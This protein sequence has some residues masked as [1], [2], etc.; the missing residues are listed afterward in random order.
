MASL[1]KD[2]E[3]L[4]TVIF[5]V[6]KLSRLRNKAKL[7]LEFWSFKFQQRLIN[8]PF[9]RIIYLCV[10]T[11]GTKFI[12]CSKQFI[13]STNY[14]FC[15]TVNSYPQ[16]LGWC[17]T[18]MLYRSY[19]IA[20]CSGVSI[21]GLIFSQF[22]CVSIILTA[23]ILYF[24]GNCWSSSTSQRLSFLLFNV[25]R[26][27]LVL[28]AIKLTSFFVV[29]CGLGRPLDSLKWSFFQTNI[30]WPVSKG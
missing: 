26:R 11:S 1:S 12:L 7:A 19:P 9:L 16:R 17:L 24:T 27:P 28:N 20:S 3:S 14:S 23:S 30:F 5:S 15:P 22:A 18:R 13:C 10:T 4:E 2:D 8:Q 29:Y 25:K 21:A 6:Y